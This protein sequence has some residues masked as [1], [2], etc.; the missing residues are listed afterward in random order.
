MRPII[1]LLVLAAAIAAI[2]VYRRKNSNTSLEKMQIENQKDDFALMVEPDSAVSFGYKCIWIAVKTIDKDSVASVLGLKNFMACNWKFGIERAYENK[3]FVSPP[4]GNWTLA[5]GWGLTDFKTESEFD[6][7]VGLKQKIDLLSKSF[8]EAQLFATHRVTEYHC[9]A[10]SVN[11]KTVRYYSYL[12]ERL[13][14]LLVEGSPTPVE[15]VLNLVNTFSKEANE[16]DYF[17]RTDITFPDEDMVMKIAESWSVNPMLLEER[18][19]IL[20]GLGLISK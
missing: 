18:K 6:E 1:I 14:N 10:K 17:E 8:G 3:V 2:I 15:S 19:D 4:V 12:G 5:V 20:P 7:S 16:D 11:G 13:K 9:W